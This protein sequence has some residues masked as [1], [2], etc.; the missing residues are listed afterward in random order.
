MEE[1]RATFTIWATTAHPTSQ[2]IRTGHKNFLVT[3]DQI[4]IS[5]QHIVHK[6]Y[7]TN[8]LDIS[9]FS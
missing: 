8:L 1:W 2:F 5:Y 3:L 9:N 4:R 7:R 6:R